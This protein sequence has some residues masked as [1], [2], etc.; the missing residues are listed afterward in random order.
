MPRPAEAKAAPLRRRLV[1][2][3]ERHGATPPGRLLW[4]NVECGEVTTPA[5]A[6]SVTTPWGPRS[7][8]LRRRRRRRRSSARGT[9]S[10]WI[11][12]CGRSSAVVRRRSPALRLA[13]AV[14]AFARRR[15][16]AL[17]HEGR[18]ARVP[19]VGEDGAARR[20]ASSR[21]RA[22]RARR[23]RR[24]RAVRR[25]RR[26]QGLPFRGSYEATREI[27]TA[28]INWQLKSAPEPIKVDVWDARGGVRPSVPRG[29]FF[30]IYL[31]ILG[32]SWTGGWR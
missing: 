30:F 13:F 1:T 21:A 12:A 32:R 18:R 24:G 16:R 3:E 31:S 4:Q 17:Q 29:T 7:R 22:R 20:P 11:R 9:S 27:S 15:R 23:R 5:V 2:T 19:R 6:R 14:S 10:A 26:L 25:W 28:T 8:R